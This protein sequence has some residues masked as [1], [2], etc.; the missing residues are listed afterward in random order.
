MPAPTP[1]DL[2]ADMALGSSGYA[3]T[4]K[5]CPT[6]AASVSDLRGHAVRLMKRREG[7]C[8]RRRC[9]GQGEGSDSN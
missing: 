9:D 5:S 3:D 1:T 6:R 4:A 2:S 8:M 7:Y